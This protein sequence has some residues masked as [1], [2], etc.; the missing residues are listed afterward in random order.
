LITIFSKEIE[1]S[2]QEV[3]GADGVSLLADNPHQTGN[4]DW[5]AQSKRGVILVGIDI[6]SSKIRSTSSFSKIDIISL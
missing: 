3:N 4:L 2:C 1:V 5:F 6:I